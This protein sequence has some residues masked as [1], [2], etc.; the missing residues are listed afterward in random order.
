[1]ILTNNLSIKYGH[2]TIDFPNLKL[3]QGEQVLLIGKSGS[4]K[5][6]FLNLIGGL[7]TP[8]SGE[9]EIDGHNI[10]SISNS[11]RDKFRGEN[12]GFIFQTPQ[13][14]Q[15]LDVENN[16]LLT[17]YLVGAYD[18]NHIDSLLLKVGLMNRKKAYLNEL[19]EGEKQRISIVRALINKPKIILADEPTSA[20]DDESCNQIIDLLKELSSENNTSL[21]IVTHD[22]R[23]KDKFNQKVE[24]NA[25]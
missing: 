22:N 3:K 25:N 6:T 19:S 16:L 8:H 20:L 14:I 17:Q 11:K 4:G 1:L 24:L 13:F 23:L 2:Q 9:V 21:I 10:V 5:T 18:K 7:L 12:I 15:S